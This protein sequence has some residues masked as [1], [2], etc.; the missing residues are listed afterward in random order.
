MIKEENIETAKPTDFPSGSVS[1]SVKNCFTSSG[2]SAPTLIGAE[3]AA[4]EEIMGI[5]IKCSDNV[6]DKIKPLIQKCMLDTPNV[7]PGF[8]LHPDLIAPLPLSIP[9]PPPAPPAVII[10]H[11]ISQ[12]YND[13]ICPTAGSKVGVRS[14]I[15]KVGT[16]YMPYTA[17]KSPL[18]ATLALNKHCYSQELCKAKMTPVCKEDIENLRS[19][20]C[21]CAKKN[22]AVQATLQ[23]LADTFTGCMQKNAGAA[24]LQTHAV[25]TFVTNA[26]RLLTNLMCIK[27]PDPCNPQQPQQ[28][29]QGQGVPQQ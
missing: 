5:L 3:G 28:G 15:R 16:K 8:I 9:N 20:L 14:C 29:A 24:S 26:Q 23:S 19:Y 12:I 7:G 4:N 6:K 18:E 27:A 1:E 11:S 22:F 10:L 2:C 13:N 21:D 17:P 25:Q